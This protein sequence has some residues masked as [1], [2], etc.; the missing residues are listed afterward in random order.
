M[1]RYLCW[2]KNAHNF[3]FCLRTFLYESW[4]KY[5]ILYLLF[6]FLQ[7]FGEQNYNIHGEDVTLYCFLFLCSN[8]RTKAL[9]STSSTSNSICKIKFCVRKIYIIPTKLIEHKQNWILVLSEKCKVDRKSGKLHTYACLHFCCTC[10][11]SYFYCSWSIADTFIFSWWIYSV[12]PSH[13]HI[14]T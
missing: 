11:G 12:R 5:G 10:N 14:H 13:T 9:S 2:D 7:I 3:F 1:G 6:S 4:S 8:A